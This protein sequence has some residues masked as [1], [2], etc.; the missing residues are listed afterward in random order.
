V[1]FR[2]EGGREGIVPADDARG[3][4]RLDGIFRILGPDDRLPVG[5]KPDPIFFSFSLIPAEII[6]RCA[7]A[8]GLYQQDQVLM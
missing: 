5:E 4:V 3:M 2:E 7:E 1:V 8:V 6:R